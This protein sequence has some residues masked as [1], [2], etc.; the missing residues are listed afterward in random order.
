MTAVVP[1]AKV[2]QPPDERR[3]GVLD[4]VRTILI[5]LV[6]S[7]H[8]WQQSWLTPSAVLFGKYFWSMDP[9]LRSGYIWVDGM[10]LLSGFLLFLTYGDRPMDRK[11]ALRFY[12][13]R[14]ARIYPSYALNV[15]V[16]FF[17]N[18][19]KY[20]NTGRALWDLAAHLNTV[21]VPQKAGL[22]LCRPVR[23]RVGFPVLG[24]HP[25][26]LRHGIQPAAGFPGRLCPGHGRRRRIPRP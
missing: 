1:K 10:I 4:G 18:L 3:V 25:Q 24:F 22:D 16:F 14:F 19:S 5:F 2:L 21:P 26:G 13:K 8:I 17:L 7:F 11:G 20:P 15:L 9:L 12:K 23:G 6:G